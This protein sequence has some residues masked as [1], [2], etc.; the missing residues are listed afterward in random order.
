MQG[1]TQEQMQ[2][3]ASMAGGVRY[4]CCASLDCPS[5]VCDDLCGGL[6]FSGGVDHIGDNLLNTEIGVR[7]SNKCDRSFGGEGVWCEEGCSSM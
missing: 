7:V 3:S 1:A 2:A 4:E 6:S 5:G